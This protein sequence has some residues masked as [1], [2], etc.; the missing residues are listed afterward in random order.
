MT[1]EYCDV[2]EQLGS[3]VAADVVVRVVE[4]LKNFNSRT[5]QL[6][7]GAGALQLVGLKTITVKHLGEGGSLPLS[8]TYPLQ[9][10][11]RALSN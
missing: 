1:A 5:C 4:V 8:Y 9:H 6:V 2:A 10:W 11:P 3:T 7:L